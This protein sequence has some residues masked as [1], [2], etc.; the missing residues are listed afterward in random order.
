[1][2]RHPGRQRQKLRP[3][4]LGLGAAS[5]IVLSSSLL[6][7]TG[8]VVDA[9][10]L[11]P[12]P[13]NV[14][15]PA[16][17]GSTGGP[18]GAGGSGGIL[19]PPPPP[20]PPGAP[21]TGP[22]ASVPGPSSRFVRLSH[23]QWE[24]TT[25]ALLRLPADSGL[26]R[27][28]LSEPIRSSFDNNGSILQVSSNLWL[29]YQ[30]A[31]ESLGA[32]AGK[33]PTLWTAFL[34]GAAATAASAR[35]FVEG[36]GL[37]A[38]RRPLTA[39]EA[40]QYTTLFSQGAT[41]VGSGNAFGDGVEVV[42]TAFLQSPHFLYRT[43]LGGGV[44]NGRVPLTDHEVASRL[45]Y[46][47]VNS[48]PDEPLLAAAGK[49]EVRTREGVLVHARR[50]L[51]S[52]AGKATL[53]DFHTQMLE[54]T[55]F[56]EIRKDTA[57][58]PL[59]KTGMGA[60]MKQETLTFV[61]DVVFAQDKGV[62]ELL[63][64]PYTFINSRL[65]PLYGLPARTPT[66][67]DPFIRTELDPTQRAGLYTQLGFLAL[68]ATDRQPRSIMRGVHLNLDA[69]CVQLPTPPDVP[70][71]T[72]SDVGKTNR[73]L[74]EAF[75]EAPG[76][77]CQSCHGSLINPLGFAFEGF[78]G[79][80]R[81]RTTDNGQPVNAA[82]KYAFSEGERTFDGAADLMKVISTSRQAHDCY[83]EHLFEYLYGRERAR[84]GAA[85]A[86]DGALVSEV[87]RRSAGKVSVKSMV[88]DLVSTDAFLTRLP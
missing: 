10:G 20:P 40:E 75:T 77:I 65:A 14:G 28:F 44:V 84:E 30:K 68:N 4:K 74:L 32:Q 15:D 73:Q 19:P 26:S 51:E 66:A 35:K 63:S 57:V 21:V 79:I 42:V 38:Y 85:G 53:D 60:E 37:R 71:E 50:L 24:N 2:T 31:A 9:T 11:V 72:P 13:G 87:G 55:P 54:L 17:G 67:G 1:M 58:N 36:F 7:C 82:G 48:M 5:I 52:E 70:P 41:L 88:L 23:R 18:P 80:G 64:A 59:W 12:P 49:G 45:S 39:A 8:T 62:G 16:S 61:R 25:R 56:E 29:D 69:L 81:T 47:L 3:R 22:L 6:G 76:S 86:A 46:G 43:E 33:T 83:A 34:G 27:E 78:D